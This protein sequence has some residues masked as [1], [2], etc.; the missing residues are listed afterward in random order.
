[1]AVT[2]FAA[3]AERSDTTYMLTKSNVSS[4]MKERFV[5]ARRFTMPAQ[6]E[7][8]EFSV[9]SVRHSFPV[10]AMAAS[11]GG[12][13]ALSIILG[14]LPPDFPGAI[15]YRWIRSHPC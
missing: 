12:L 1:M 11:V 6:G 15:F 10:I 4:P 13:K 3:Y 7:L 8:L 14:D 2:G 5:S 9:A